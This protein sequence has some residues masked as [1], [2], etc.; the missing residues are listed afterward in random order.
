M[1]MN[2]Q[3]GGALQIGRDVDGYHYIFANSEGQTKTIG[4]HWNPSTL[5]FEV[6]TGGTS[7]GPDVNVS[8]FPATQTVNGAVNVSGGVNVNENPKVTLVYEDEDV[9]YVCKATPGSSPSSAAWQIIKYDTSGTTL[10]IQAQYCDG[11]ANYD[12]T[13]TDLVTVEGHSYA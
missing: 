4:Y 6:N 1:V 9:L 11:N 3:G 10:P 8:N 5:A 12:N 13:A 7:T 2:Y